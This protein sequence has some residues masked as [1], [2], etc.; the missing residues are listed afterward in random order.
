MYDIE[1]IPTIP[2]QARRLEEVTVECYGQYEE[3][4][5]A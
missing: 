2:D 5:G 4:S 1:D 3:L